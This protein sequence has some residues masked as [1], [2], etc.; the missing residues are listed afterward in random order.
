LRSLVGSDLNEGGNQ[1]NMYSFAPSSQKQQ[2]KTSGRGQS[3]GR[4]SS[5]F[6]GSDEEDTH[7]QTNNSTLPTSPDPMGFDTRS[8]GGRSATSPANS[9]Y[10]RTRSG[11][12]AAQRSA[13]AVRPSDVY[14]GGH[15]LTSNKNLAN[16]YKS[17]VGYHQQLNISVDES[18]L[19]D[20]VQFS[21]FF[22]E[23]MKDLWLRKF[24]EFGDICAKLDS[25]DGNW[26]LIQFKTPAQAQ[27]AISHMNGKKIRENIVIAQHVD[28]DLAQDFKSAF[29]NNESRKSSLSTNLVA[30]EDSLF[31]HSD[32]SIISNKAQKKENFPL[33]RDDIFKPPRKH[34]SCCAWLLEFL[35]CS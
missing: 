6:D 19:Q 1:G 4:K 26:I 11:S 29:R 14:G 22:A 33:G 13:A 20:W 15:S 27:S 18:S 3:G 32:Y 5:Y 17:A 9:M 28:R 34:V 2:L 12:S 7:V 31:R 24:A 21:G 30:S 8:G 10:S 16:V 35:S 23:E 25:P